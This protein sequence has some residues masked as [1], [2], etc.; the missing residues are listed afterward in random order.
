MYC[1]RFYLFTLYA[2]TVPT[3]LQSSTPIG[4]TFPYVNVPCTQVVIRKRKR[5]QKKSS[6]TYNEA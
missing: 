5:I 1:R 2:R 4:G 3:V 6:T